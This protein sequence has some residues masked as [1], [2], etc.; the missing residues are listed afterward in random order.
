M[1]I[2]EFN[3]GINYISNQGESR[4]LQITGDN[5]AIFSLEIQ[6]TVGSTITFYDFNTKTFVSS[7]K[8]LKNR[9]ITNGSFSISINFPA[10]GLTVGQGPDTYNLF[11]HAQN[12]L[13][14]FHIPY[15]DAR[16]AD[17]SVD[18]NNTIGSSSSLLERVLYQYPDAKFSITGLSPTPLAGFTSFTATTAE[19]LLQAGSSTG[20]IPFSFVVTLASNKSGVILKQP[21]TN[22]LTAFTTL[23]MGEPYFRIPGVFNPAESPIEATINLPVNNSNTITIA[24]D[25]VP[26][27]ITTESTMTDAAGFNFSSEGPSVVT[28][29]SGNTITLNNAV[30]IPNVAG[31]SDVK[32]QAIKYPR[33]RVPSA[34]GKLHQLVGGMEI[35]GATADLTSGTVLKSYR[36]VTTL[37]REITR[38]DG[39][40]YEEDYNVVN[41][42]VPV[43]DTLGLKPTITNGL[44]EFQGGVIT[45][46]A[47]QQ[48]TNVRNTNSKAYAYGLSS[49]KTISGVDIDITDLKIELEE[50]T[51]TVN[52]TDANNADALTSFDVASTDGILDDVSTVHGVNLNSGVATP[53]VTNISSNT[54]TLTPGGHVLQNGQVLTFKG[55]GRVFTISGKVKVNEMS[56]RNTI[57]YFDLERFISAS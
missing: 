35:F 34:S 25:E 23:A 29:I 57:L 12:E 20:F 55:A 46:N 40:V 14:T 44:V 43:I 8:R 39:S 37:K 11:L 15:I 5:G 51:T 27:G 31:N 26:G 54:I 50:I 4:E 52:D 2:K 32:F 7:R 28:N 49:I 18:I 36:D 42:N 41:H 21:G 53:V 6:R 19:L 30:T 1:E 47:A 13:D 38:S 48:L 17:G 10:A 9:K 3:Y 24:T 16:F 33:W 45:L 22:D 56:V